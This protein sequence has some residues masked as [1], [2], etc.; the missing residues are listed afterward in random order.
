MIIAD[1]FIVISIIAII[2]Y[3]IYQSLTIIMSGFSYQYSYLMSGINLM[4]VALFF[5]VISGYKIKAYKTSL[6][7][8]YKSKKYT[9][10]FG[11]FGSFV[12]LM[13]CSLLDFLKITV[14]RFELWGEA[15]YEYWLILNFVFGDF[16]PVWFQIGIIFHHYW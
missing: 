16:F 7:F 11:Y 9:I 10:L 15:N 4:T 2:V 14:P 1:S 8:F 12:P 6:P 3:Y 5:M 13:I